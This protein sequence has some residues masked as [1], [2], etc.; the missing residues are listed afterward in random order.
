M[1]LSSDARVVRARHTGLRD[2]L[3]RDLAARNPRRRM[4]MASSAGE[5]PDVAHSRRALGR[6]RSGPRSWIALGGRRR[7]APR[8]VPVII[9]LALLAVFGRVQTVQAAAFSN[10]G[11]TNLEETGSAANE[12]Q[13]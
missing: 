9:F 4:A 2:L 1:G 11:S 13:A 3:R 6:W 12:P 5:T 7:T 10:P 8:P